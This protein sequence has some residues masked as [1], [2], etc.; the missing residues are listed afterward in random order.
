MPTATTVD[1]K[2]KRCIHQHV[3]GTIRI[4]RNG[5][6]ICFDVPGDGM[7][8]HDLL[9]TA[10]VRATDDAEHGY[11]VVGR[12]F[13]LFGHEE[14]TFGEEYLHCP[15]G[16]LPVV[17][18]LLRKAGYRVD[19]RRARAKPLPPYSLRDEPE[20]IELLR[21]VQQN[22]RALI[23]YSPQNV[24]PAWLVR[25]VVRAWPNESV[26]VLCNRD[27][28][29]EMVMRQFTPSGATLATRR[30]QPVE[31]CRVLVASASFAAGHTEVQKRDIAIV[32]D[33]GEMFSRRGLD[34]YKY[35]YEARLY[36]L[37]PEGS[38]TSPYV[39]DLLLAAFGFEELHIPEHGC[40]FEPPEV[41]Y[42]PYS[43]GVRLRTEQNTPMKVK[44][45]GIW[46]NNGRNQFL[47]RLCRLC[48]G[49]K[50]RGLTVPPQ[51][52]DS[53]VRRQQP[54]IAVVVEN[55]DHALALGRL[56]PEA[57]LVT[58]EHVQLDGLS[59]AAEERFEAVPS[60]QTQI[61]IVTMAALP[62]MPPTDVIVRADACQSGMTDNSIIAGRDS[63][64]VDVTDRHHPLLR[65]WS[66]QRRTD[67]KAAGWIIASARPDSPLERFKAT[68]PKDA[69][70]AWVRETEA[71][72]TV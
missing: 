32:L 10:M 3:K 72:L 5:Q 24:D 71:S 42:V 68:R 4:W 46:K 65:R 8:V 55:L 14:G 12:Y 67:Y 19:A 17:R 31:I 6:R 21:L 16:L 57:E 41:F 58:A 56:L 44:Q 28:E 61:S 11:C 60:R 51:L 40:V 38:T 39:R 1:R 7:I 27:S 35:S 9:Y 34:A 18:E 48:T 50:D 30:H 33:A 63:L 70:N 2:H 62:T 20:D 26:M 54:S 37:V 22:E 53:L 36:G 23:T 69:L 47:A 45:Y 49:G 43:G 66:Q 59:Q 64:I 15:P 52:I 13:P 25:Q 29:A